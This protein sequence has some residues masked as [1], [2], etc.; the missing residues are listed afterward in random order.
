MQEAEEKRKGNPTEG[1]IEFASENVEFKVPGR[2]PCGHKC[3]YADKTA[4]RWKF[5][6]DAEDRRK[7]STLRF[8]FLGIFRVMFLV[9]LMCFIK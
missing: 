1:D 6:I 3:M 9:I 4:S 8:V 7:G 5:R 2:Q